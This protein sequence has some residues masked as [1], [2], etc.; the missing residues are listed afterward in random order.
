MTINPFHWN[1]PPFHWDDPTGG[2]ALYVGKGGFETVADAVVFI[3]TTDRYTVVYNTGTITLTN[4]SYDATPSGGADFSE[5]STTA[6]AKELWI[7]LTDTNIFIPL[8]GMTP[9]LVRPTHTFGDYGQL[10]Y[11]YE[12]TTGAKNYELVTPNWSHIK[13]LP[14]EVRDP[15]LI[16]WPMFTTISGEGK[17]TCVWRCACT[18]N[19]GNSGFFA[20]DF[21]W[22]S[23]NDVY[24]V[25]SPEEALIVVEN[26]DETEMGYAELY[27]RRIS[28]GKGNAD[29]DVTY[30]D[31][32][33]GSFS[34]ALDDIQDCELY[35]HY[36]AVQSIARN[37]TFRNNKIYINTQ[38]TT[39]MAPT[40]LRWFSGL[41][42]PET[43]LYV[44][45]CGNQFFI[46]ATGNTA[47][48]AN[49]LILIEDQAVYLS[50]PP[51]VYGQILDNHISV[52]S[53]GSGAI[54]GIIG[55]TNLFS[56]N[57]GRVLIDRN[58]FDVV[59][60][61]GGADTDIATHATA[62]PFVLGKNNIRK[63]GGALTVTGAPFLLENKGTSSAIASGATIAHGLRATPTEITVTPADTGVTDFYA[64][65]DG[66]NITVTYS[67]G[68]THAFNWKVSI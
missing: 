4:G 20:A 14:G 15:A 42:A 36:D 54:A 52:H 40:G 6:N 1:S 33:A 26:E 48:F 49:G 23:I 62:A 35:A 39:V 18:M 58:T 9:N 61:G 59:C 7:H 37:L 17:E 12:G 45:I 68:G 67:G 44:D 5:L 65:A 63:D 64:T 50:A 43:A 16:T 24:G 66:T 38:D 19:S 31:N 22:G 41:A 51:D 21:K 56:A 53:A 60:T 27:M 57:D 55:P 47:K 29:R 2:N 30:R 8:V 32:T 28:G 46:E 3:N 25:T 34:N 10:K 11:K 13:L